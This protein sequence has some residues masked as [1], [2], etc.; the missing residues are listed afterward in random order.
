MHIAMNSLFIVITCI[1]W[2]FDINPL[3]DSDGN[4]VIPSTED[5]I[6]GLIIRPRPFTFSLEFRRPEEGTEEVIVMESKQAKD[7][8]MSWQ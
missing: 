2:A 5:F 6:G 3:K 8:D 4:P 7:G 1:L